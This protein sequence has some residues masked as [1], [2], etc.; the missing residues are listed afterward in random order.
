MSQ[1]AWLAGAAP[2][3]T[4]RLGEA[5]AMPPGMVHAPPP[6]GF[7]LDRA[8]RIRRPPRAAAGGSQGEGLSK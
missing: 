5:H 1:A 4:A 2:L 3:E 7:K 8:G 6:R